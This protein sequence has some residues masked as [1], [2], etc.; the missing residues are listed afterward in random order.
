M[1]GAQVGQNLHFIRTCCKELC[2]ATK[3]AQMVHV[4][5]QHRHSHLDST[6]VCSR[7]TPAKEE[8]SRNPINL[9]ARRRVF[10]VA[11]GQLI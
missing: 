8:R 6:L 3:Y 4:V 10:H 11:P 7:S 5:C 1:A 2:L 9:R